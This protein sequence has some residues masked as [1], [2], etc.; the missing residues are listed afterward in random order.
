MSAST[1]VRPADPPA[2]VIGPSDVADPTGRAPRRWVRWLGLALGLLALATAGGAWWRTRP[3]PVTSRHLT[4]RIARADLEESVRATGTVQ[5]LVEVQVGAQVSGR[6][7]RVAVDFNSRVRRGD[8]LA[9]IDATTYRAQ[10]EQAAASLLAAQATLA[11]N[12]A[13]LRLTERVLARAVALRS[14]GLNAQADVDQASAQREMA[15]ASVDL[16]TAQIAQARA[17]LRSARTNLTFTRVEAPIDGVVA[18]RAVDPG[19]TVAASFQ[20]PTLFVIANDLT[21]MR[22][23]ADVDEANIGRLR[24]G[25]AA[26]ARVDAFPRETFGGAVSQLRITP[27]STSGVVTYATVIALANPELKL[28]PGMTAT[29]TI[30]TRRR[31]DALCV[32]NAALR[33]RPPSAARPSAEPSPGAGTVYVL[34]GGRA[35]PV[36]VAA[37]IT[38]GVVTEVSGEGLRVGDEVILDDTDAAGARSAGGARMRMF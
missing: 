4:A 15:A 25:M 27:T 33:Y 6:I 31:P 24:E 38:N 5:P 22:V 37:G 11:Q 28:R 14:G 19:Q 10:A 21:Q 36:A 17:S 1:S 7:L 18:T 13:N 12:R 34:R 20:T 35:A 9:E 23:M 29:I 16:A 32:P 26:V 8:L 3:R 2:V 30:V